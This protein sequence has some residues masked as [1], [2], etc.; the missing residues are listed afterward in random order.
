MK[1]KWTLVARHM[2]PHGQMRGKLEQKIRKLEKHI[3]HFPAD[4]VH[5]QVQL[6]R[7][8]RK[9]DFEVALTLRLPS[10][11]LRSEKTGSDPVAAFDQAIK[12]LLRELA[13]LKSALR[14]ESQ[15]QRRSW[16]AMT[17]MMHGLDRSANHAAVP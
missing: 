2:R 9:L 3:E 12:V 17:G 1:L 5:L 13:M 16:P 8:A 4:A 15:W 10:G 6:E 11:V 7:H 14:R